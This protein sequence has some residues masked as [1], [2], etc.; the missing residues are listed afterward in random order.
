MWPNR[1]EFLIALFMALCMFWGLVYCGPSQAEPGDV[2]VSWMSVPNATIYRVHWGT[3]IDKLDR[4]IAVDYGTE[5]S[6]PDLKCNTK[7]FAIVR[8]YNKDLPSPPTQTI[9]F[10]TGPCPPQMIMPEGWDIQG[11]WLTPANTE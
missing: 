4:S 8:A 11:I 2:E 3:E 5:S 9:E 10:T 1:K 6:I 7:Y